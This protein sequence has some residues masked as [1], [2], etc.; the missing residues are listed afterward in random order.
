MESAA[1]QLARPL[2]PILSQGKTMHMSSRRAFVAID[3]LFAWHGFKEEAR[4]WIASTDLSFLAPM[5]DTAE[6]AIYVG[7]EAGLLGRFMQQV[8]V[9]ISRI[10]NVGGIV[11]LE[12]TRFGDYHT[13]RSMEYN[14]YPDIIVVKDQHQRPSTLRVTGEMKPFWH[15][16]LENID[17]N[18]PADLPELQEPIGKS[19]PRN[20]WE[21]VTL[22]VH[23]FTK[24]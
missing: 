20:I 6:E 4:S 24:S 19:I 23:L 11:E 9:V 21:P 16:G 13:V 8:G 7:N 5:E 18:N 22:H 1:T 15:L 17:V 14:G 2:P 10:C 12:G 3:Y